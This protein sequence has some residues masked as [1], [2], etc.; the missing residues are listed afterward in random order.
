M[1]FLASSDGHSSQALRVSL[2]A[3]RSS[4]VVKGSSSAA[5]D[6]LAYHVIE[7]ACGPR[8]APASRLIEFSDDEWY[9]VKRGLLARDPLCSRALDTPFFLCSAWV[10]GTTLDALGGSAFAPE[11]LQQLGALC[12]IDACLGNSDR[13]PVRAACSGE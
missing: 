4:L 9:A 2:F 11:L 13:L 5:R 8:A 3:A 7:R 12:L 1:G 10:D 6:W